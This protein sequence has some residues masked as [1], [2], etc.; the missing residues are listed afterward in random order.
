[1]VLHS[2]IHTT[3]CAILVALAAGAV[4]RGQPTLAKD[5]VPVKAA[6]AKAVAPA[7]AVAAKAVAP[8]KAA[9]AK[10]AK[11]LAKAVAPAKA[12][13]AKAVVAKAVVAK[14]AVAKAVD[15]KAVV[16]KAAVAKPHSEVETLEALNKGLKT[17]HNLRA[18]FSK[19]KK[20]ER[21]AEKFANGAL[22]EELSNKDSQVWSTIEN[23]LGAT[24]DAMKSVQGKSKTER[25]QVMKSLE[26]E[27]DKKATVLSKVNDD[28]SKKQE[29]QD[30]E[31]L[32]GLLLLHKD[33]WSME[34]QLN[35]TKTFMHNSPILKNLFEHHDTSKPLAPQ[36]AAMLDA[37][38]KQ[39]V[40]TKVEAKKPAAKQGVAKAA[41][42]AAK[43]MFIQLANTYMN[44][45]CPFCVAQCVG[46]CHTAGNPYTQCMTDC[47]DS[48]K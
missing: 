26:G 12:A 43:T 41:S 27:L 18:L 40:A 44:R 45:D 32:L 39:V 48:G 38:P 37:K 30:E 21:G 46:K 36:L 34:K 22:S 13:V 6:A 28:V 5:A 15:A 1:M 33:N 35:A 2:K 23:M 3:V 19:D 47:A 25:E 24:Q 4:F 8:V 20:E 11:P 16:A 9:V 29:Q 10:A 42:S 31:Y 7:K 14:A 17:I